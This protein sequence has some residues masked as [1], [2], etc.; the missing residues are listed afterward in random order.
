MLWLFMIDVMICITLNFFAFRDSIYFIK[1][2]FYW[3]KM[4][5]LDSCGVLI[6]VCCCMQIATLDVTDDDSELANDREKMNNDN[7]NYDGSGNGSKNSK[8]SKI[9]MAMISTKIK[10]GELSKDKDDSFV[11]Y[12]NNVDY[13]N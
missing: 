4:L 11:R 2:N 5:C 8:N 12:E 1:H 9:A 6:D 3:L 10:F 13:Q 7:E